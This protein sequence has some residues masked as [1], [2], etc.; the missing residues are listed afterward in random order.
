[1]KTLLFWLCFITVIILTL[2]SILFLV[3]KEMFKKHKIFNLLANAQRQNKLNKVGENKYY[4][5][6]Y[7]EANK[8]RKARGQNYND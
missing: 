5:F 3:Q 2:V 4:G 1:M 6:L 8:S 7:D